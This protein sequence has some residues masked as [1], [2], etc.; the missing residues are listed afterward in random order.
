MDSRSPAFAED[1]FRGNDDIQGALHGIVVPVKAGIHCHRRGMVIPAKLVL[2]ESGGAGIH[3][4]CL[5][6]RP[7]TKAFTRPRRMA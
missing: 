4:H 1:K 7:L 2:R 5:N 6:R 3:C